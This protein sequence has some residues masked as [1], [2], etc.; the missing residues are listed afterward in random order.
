M[1][2]EA[3]VEFRQLFRRHAIRCTVSVPV[4]QHQGP[5][6]EPSRLSTVKQQA[7]QLLKVKRPGRYHSIL[8]SA[9]SKQALCFMVYI[10][11]GGELAPSEDL[12]QEG[13]QAFEAALSQFNMWLRS[14]T[15]CRGALIAAAMAYLAYSINF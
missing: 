1:A 8:R 5:A 13:A 9:H 11:F 2:L 3:K 15:R 12:L 10:M 7:K 6:E 14:S 4:P